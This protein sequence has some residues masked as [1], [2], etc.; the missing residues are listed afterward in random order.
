MANKSHKV[1][2]NLLKWCRVFQEKGIMF[3]QTEFTLPEHLE[4]NWE[5]FSLF[6]ETMDFDKSQKDWQVIDEYL[7]YLNFDTFKFEQEYIS[8]IGQR[9]QLKTLFL[10][11][12]QSKMKTEFTSIKYY[13]QI[14][15][16]AVSTSQFKTIVSTMEGD[17][18]NFYMTHKS[19]RPHLVTSMKVSFLFGYINTKV[20]DVKDN[21]K[22]VPLL[23]LKM[24]MVKSFLSFMTLLFNEF[25]VD[26]DLN[27]KI[28]MLYA[29][30]LI[31]ND[32]KFF[33]TSDFETVQ[34]K[35]FEI[36]GY[37]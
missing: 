25:D 32:F 4:E 30:N 29:L 10:N 33:F 17:V 7:L 37:K 24:L 36:G 31:Y 9:S 14:C 6:I 19:I 26:T 28:S 12:M 20:H 5:F 21:F 3:K 8:E 34:L 11:V 23:D 35:I 15:L 16:E 22:D 18:K 1:T 13:I 2:D 27:E